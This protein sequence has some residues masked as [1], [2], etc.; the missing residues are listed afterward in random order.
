MFSRIIRR[1]VSVSG[2]SRSSTKSNLLIKNNI[3]LDLLLVSSNTRNISSS[4]SF[5]YSKQ[6]PKEKPNDVDDEKP[7]LDADKIKNA[8]NKKKKSTKKST[9]V[10]ELE[11]EKLK[12]ESKES[13]QK[14]DNE[15]SEKTS[16]EAQSESQ[17]EFD[18]DNED[19]SKKKDYD[20]GGGMFGSDMVIHSFANTS[21]KEKETF[22][23]C[24]RMYKNAPGRKLERVPFL[25]AALKYMDEFGVA[26]DLSIYKALID[27]L[28]KEKMVPTNLFQTMFLHYPKEQYC[29]TAILEK[30]EDNGVMP[31]PEMELLL[32]A[33]FGR[34]GMP[35]EKYWKMM[36]WMPKFEHL[37]PWP[38]PKPIP[39]DAFELAKLA[40]IKIS[41]I[42]VKSEVI[43]FDT[44]D[45]E[46]S[47]DKTWI[48]S[49]MAPKQS[50]LLLK[51]D[52]TKAIY[53]EGP[54]KI[55]VAT[56]SVDYYTLRT[57][58]DL[59]REFPIPDPDGKNL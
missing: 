24:L 25:Y 50:E 7:N 57:D 8:A 15:K 23:E 11:K 51:H 36:Y 48:V 49:A 27:I 52:K 39:N 55:Y 29:V 5:L 45:V 28:P 19:N 43:E 33:I 14:V 38:V 54:F 32:L 56:K 47:I 30:M 4:C 20:R 9:V 35:L 41:S 44:N 21:T 46:D 1:S 31:D 6:N 10:E 13:A 40:M 3:Q 58:P 59:T 12:N 16:D 42:D 17:D 37:N 53:V 22:L 18:E 34:H 2:I 26:K